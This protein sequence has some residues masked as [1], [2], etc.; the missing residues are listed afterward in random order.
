[1]V[2]VIVD[3]R[4]LRLADR[5]FDRMKLLCQIEAGAAFAEHLDNP[6]KMA[7]RPLQPLDDIGMSFVNVIMCHEQKV[8]PLG[9]YGKIWFV[10][11]GRDRF[12]L[13]PRTSIV[14]GRGTTIAMGNSFIERSL[15]R[16]LRR[17]FMW[18]TAS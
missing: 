17:A 14:A 5:L 6:V 7:F 4:L 3:Q 2:D 15:T 18:F 10:V 1:V 9:G 16:G 11:S 8:S 12:S 13:C